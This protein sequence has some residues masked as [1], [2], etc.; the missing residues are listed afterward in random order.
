MMTTNHIGRQLHQMQQESV[1][2]V[3][4]FSLCEES[5]HFLTHTQLEL[6]RDCF[7]IFFYF[8][9]S[10]FFYSEFLTYCTVNTNFGFVLVRYPP[11]KLNFR[12]NSLLQLHTIAYTLCSMCT[13]VGRLT[14]N[15]I[16][17][18]KVRMSRL[19]NYILVSL[20]TQFI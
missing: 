15:L 10:K 2:R 19:P 4:A 13:K 3:H 9:E 1:V 8:H 16:E 7:F 18:K 6:P 17:W 14:S 5:V 20:L 12:Q 11:K